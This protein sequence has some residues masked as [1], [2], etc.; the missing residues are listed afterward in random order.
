MF[1]T[2]GHQISCGLSI[3]MKIWLRYFY[4]VFCWLLQSI[5]KLLWKISQAIILVK[6]SKSISISNFGHHGIWYCTMSNNFKTRASWQLWSGF[7]NVLPPIVRSFTVINTLHTCYTWQLWS[8]FTTVLPPTV[9]YCTMSY[10]SKTRASRQLWLGFIN[11]LPPIVRSFS[12]INTHWALDVAPGLALS[13]CRV[14]RAGALSPGMSGLVSYV[15]LGL[16]LPHCR[17]DRAG[18]F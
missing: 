4:Y 9:R 15:A 5:L 13:H 12:V 2:T 1:I 8:G 14:G 10:N 17:V 16:A 7:I 3:S 6:I 18:A 11:V